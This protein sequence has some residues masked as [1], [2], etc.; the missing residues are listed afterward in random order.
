MGKRVELTLRGDQVLPSVWVY[1]AMGV[2]LTPMAMEHRAAR[3]K[4]SLT[5]Y[6]VSAEV[7]DQSATVWYSSIAR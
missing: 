7:S 1:V 5:E 2:G 4:Y 3:R 6:L